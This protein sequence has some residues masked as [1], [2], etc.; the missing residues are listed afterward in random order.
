M[1]ERFAPLPKMMKLWEQLQL[2]VDDREDS[3][4][5]YWI[6]SDAVARTLTIG[7]PLPEPPPDFYII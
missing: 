6:P 1:F 5:F 7:S 2:K 4:R 3:V